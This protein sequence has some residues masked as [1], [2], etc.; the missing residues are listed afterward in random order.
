ML[1][2]QRKPAGHHRSI[3]SYTLAH[4]SHHGECVPRHEVTRNIEVA[5][6]QFAS[7]PLRV[8]YSHFVHARRSI[9]YHP[10]NVGETIVQT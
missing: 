7:A 1:C 2:T 8:P 4:N 10:R 3:A 9:A 5:H 6:N